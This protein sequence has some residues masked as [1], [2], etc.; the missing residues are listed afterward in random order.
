MILVVRMQLAYTRVLCATQVRQ[1]S[2]RK[3]FL[4]NLYRKSVYMQQYNAHTESLQNTGA[5]WF[6]DVVQ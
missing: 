5:E 3:S 4:L 2:C 1:V 6:V